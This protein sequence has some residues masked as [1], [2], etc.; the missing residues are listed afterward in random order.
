MKI[1]LKFIGTMGVLFFTSQV[2]SALEFI[3][4]ES[5]GQNHISSTELKNFY[6][7]NATTWNNGTKV[8]P[9][10]KDFSTDEGK[11]FL[12]EVIGKSSRQY[13]K[14]WMS[15]ELSG[16]GT[17]PGQLNSDKEMLDFVKSNKG[18]IGF[19]KDGSSLPSGVKRMVVKFDGSAE[20]NF[21]KMVKL[22][23]G[24]P[25]SEIEQKATKGRTGN[26][27]KYHICIEPELDL[28]SGCKIYCSK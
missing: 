27:F 3:V 24:L 23:C 16:E 19:V 25:D 12:S 26:I 8:Q 14:S 1:A 5:V 2:A 6:E 20:E 28:G 7:G 17:I 22:T 15:K 18:A 4:H 9:K 21:K 11:T 13:Q 10:L